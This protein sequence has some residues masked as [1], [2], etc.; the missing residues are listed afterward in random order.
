MD[1]WRIIRYIKVVFIEP[2]H[3]INWGG[4]KI[5]ELDD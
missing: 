5:Y 3:G 4:F 1:N 2:P